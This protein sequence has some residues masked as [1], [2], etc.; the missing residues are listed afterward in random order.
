MD[1]PL[2]KISFS[3]LRGRGQPLDLLDVLRTSVAGFLCLWL[4]SPDVGETSWRRRS[5]RHGFSDRK[6][7]FY[8]LTPAWKSKSINYSLFC[9]ILERSIIKSTN[10]FRKKESSISFISKWHREPYLFPE[11]LKVEIRMHGDC[12][13]EAIRKSG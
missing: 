4:E 13:L 1:G 10:G 12:Y 2:Y 8:T 9:N 11:L 5:G 7:I 6:I 3:E